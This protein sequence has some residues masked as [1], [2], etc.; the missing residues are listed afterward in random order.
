MNAL[1]TTSLPGVE[2]IARGK[3]RDVYAHSGN[4]LIVATDR[5]SAFDCVLP[6]GIPGK[7]AVLTAMSLFWFDLLG[8]VVP[9]HL[10]ATD[11]DAYP[12]DLHQFR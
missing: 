10:I 3:V 6:Q 1:T 11:V 12:S 5:I 4:L 8:D 9:N 7:G 2:L